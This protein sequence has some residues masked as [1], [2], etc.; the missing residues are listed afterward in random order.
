MLKT[1]EDFHDLAMAYFYRAK[2]MG[3]LYCEVMFDIQAHT[4]RGVGI[5]IVMRGLESARKK[6]EITLGVGDSFLFNLKEMVGAEGN[7]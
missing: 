2:D 4:R 1:K 6:A 5:A 3:V 7:S